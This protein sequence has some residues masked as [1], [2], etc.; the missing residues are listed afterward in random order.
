MIL[1]KIKEQCIRSIQAGIDSLDSRF[2]SEA[3]ED[4]IRV[5]RLELFILSVNGSR[6]MAANS[7]IPGQWALTY[8]SVIDVNAQ[9][10]EAD[11]LVFSKPRTVRNNNHSDG[12]LFAGKEKSPRS[13]TQLKSWEQAAMALDL[14]EIY[15]NGG[16]H[17]LDE[18]DRLVIFGN[19]SLKRLKIRAVFED[20]Q[21]IPDF[22][23]YNDDYPMPDDLI[24]QLVI[25]VRDR[26]LAQQ[27][28]GIPDLTQSGN[29]LTPPKIN[30]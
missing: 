12:I 6:T 27:Q 20:P 4:L 11:Y 29:D 9:D 8:L 1:E 24:P 22:D 30:R 15:A 10:S 13:F 28:A 23:V 17:F 19:K 3:I 2:E 14:E 7:F 21:A 26:F 18:G 16:E 25:M 5:V